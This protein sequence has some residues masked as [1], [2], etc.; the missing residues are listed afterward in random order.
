MNWQAAYG[1]LA[2]ALIFGALGALLPKTAGILRERAALIATA[3]ALLVGIAPTLHGL[4]GM[5]SVTL[6]CFAL[7]QHVGKTANP[8][9]LRSA[10]AIFA[11]GVFFYPAS[12]GWG[13]FDPYPMGFQPWSLLP[14]LTTGAAI[15]LWRGLQWPALI[16]SLAFVAYASGL[17][18]N[19]WDALIDP[20]L[21]LLSGALLL[22]HYLLPLI[23]KWLR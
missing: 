14:A 9:T 23:A 6:L 2:H 11:F 18:S 17:F 16:L 20:L 7:I 1:L 3:S 5:P 4:F 10:W 13:P 21:F 12:Q 22:R 19:L 15:L 8:L